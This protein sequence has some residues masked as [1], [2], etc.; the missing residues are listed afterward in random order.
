MTDPHGRTVEAS[1]FRA[2]PVLIPAAGAAS[3][4]GSRKLLEMVDG[5]PM[6]QR[7]VVSLRAGGAGYVLVTVRPGDRALSH[8]LEPIAGLASF[9][10]PDWAE[11][12]ASSY[13]LLIRYL[14]PDVPF[15]LA[16]PADLPWLRSETVA[17][18]IAAAARTPDRLIVPTYRGRPGHPVAIP[19]SFLRRARQLQGDEGFRRWRGEALLIDVDDPGLVRDVD[20]PEDIG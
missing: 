3:R 11:G 7:T 20:R 6:I 4:Y 8:A 9:D 10:N 18:V 15:A 2:P 12:M 16:C 19:P 1:L 5:F 13:R 17:E 14:S